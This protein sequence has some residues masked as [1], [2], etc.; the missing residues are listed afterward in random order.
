MNEYQ[1]LREKLFSLATTHPKCTLENVKKANA[2]LNFPDKTFKSIHIAGTNGKGSVTTKIAY[3]LTYSGY[4]TGLYTSPHISSYRERIAIDGVYI[5]KGESTKILNE[6]FKLQKDLKIYLSFFEITTLLAFVYFSRKKVDFAVLETGLG[7]RLD[8][9]NI[10]TPIVSI[11]TTITY[12]HTNILGDTLEDIAYE[13]AQIIKPNVPVIIGPKAHFAPIL[14]KAKESNSLTIFAKDKKGFY[15]LQNQQIAKAALQII[16]QKYPLKKSAITKGLKIRPKGRFEVVKNII[17]KVVIYDVAHNEDGFLELK[18][19]IEHFYP[20]E[21]F[22]VVLGFSKY[23]DIQACAKI[24]K[25]FARFVH[26]ISAKSFKAVSQEDIEREFIKANLKKYK[27]EKDTNKAFSLAK[28]LAQK[29]DEILL[30][31]GSFYVVN[32][33]KMYLQDILID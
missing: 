8:A 17:P 32:E 11:I 19:A 3:S 10:V 21:K 1:K 33:G 14:D 26:I 25:T 9:T 23:K 15:D 20:N 30:V 22:R 28:E 18:K 16:S 31:C 13:K 2:T 24:I 6:I 5:S 7:G 12:D 27:I 4:K 29:N